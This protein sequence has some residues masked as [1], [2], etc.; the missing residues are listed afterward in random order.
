MNKK[1]VSY[2]NKRVHLSVPSPERS[3]SVPT[4]E[5]IYDDAYMLDSTNIKLFIDNLFKYDDMDEFKNDFILV[6]YKNKQTYIGTNT[7]ARIIISM[8]NDKW[9]TCSLKDC[10]SRLLKVKDKLQFQVSIH[11]LQSFKILI[12]S[13]PFITE[14]E[15][16]EDLVIILDFCTQRLLRLH[17]GYANAIM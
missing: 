13:L 7:N 11:D 8:K 14:S 10:K 16:E 6:T 15:D 1:E 9:V 17:K 4:Y 12:T 2:P 3:D 5:I